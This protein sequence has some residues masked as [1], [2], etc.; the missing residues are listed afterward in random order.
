MNRT[1]TLRRIVRSCRTR[2]NSMK[3]APSFLTTLAIALALA[4]SSVFALPVTASATQPSE[5]P[6]G[7][8]FIAKY[9]ISG[10]GTPGFAGAPGQDVITF[11]DLQIVGN[12]L[13]QF[14]FTSTVPI[15]YVYV[16]AGSDPGDSGNYDYRSSPVTSGN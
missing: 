7:T 15:A 13:K 6:S 12:E 1:R 3:R 2:S 9:E 16:K 11:S 4:L 14:D 10:S 8:T 5:C